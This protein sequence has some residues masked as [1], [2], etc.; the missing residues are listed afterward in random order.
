MTRCCFRCL[1]AEVW[2]DGWPMKTDCELAQQVCV[3]MKAP[4]AMIYG[5]FSSGS[6]TSLVSLHAMRY[7][8]R[9]R[10]T[11]LASFAWADEAV[12]WPVLALLRNMMHSLIG[13]LLSC[14]FQLISAQAS[15]FSDPVLDEEAWRFY[16]LLTDPREGCC[17][18]C[19]WSLSETEWRD[20]DL[21]EA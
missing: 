5:Q 7:W 11:C 17:W 10:A 12:T 15:R 9:W 3:Q 8:K 13:R 1:R 21:S 19:Y 6:E 14:L 4:C 16:C 20:S 2:C 18:F